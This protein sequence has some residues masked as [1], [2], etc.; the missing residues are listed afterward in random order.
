VETLRDKG[1]EMQDLINKAKTMQ[2]NPNLDPDLKALLDKWEEVNRKILE[3][4][5]KNQD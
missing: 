1:I 4:Y 5:P 2:T 3:K